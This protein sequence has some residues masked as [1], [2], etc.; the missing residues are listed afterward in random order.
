MPQD[1]RDTDKIILDEIRN[2]QKDVSRIDLN[3]ALNTQETTRL[4]QYQE[5]M[6][7]RVAGHESRMQI[8][9]GAQA[10]TS[11]AV[12]K[13]QDKEEKQDDKKSDWTDWLLKGLV[14]LGLSIA[15]YILTHNGFPNFLN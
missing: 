5:K 13:I 12:A 15:Y 9:E 1:R 10:I 3:L 6:N 2:L 8:I 14:V 11:T 4:A 7:G